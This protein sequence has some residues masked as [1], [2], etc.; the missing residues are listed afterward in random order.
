VIT[1]IDTT[2]KLST[3]LL[4]KSQIP[5]H[6]TLLCKTNHLN[7][8]FWTKKSY[9]KHINFFTGETDSLATKL[10]NT[11]ANANTAT[12]VMTPTVNVATNATT[13]NLN[14]NTPTI[15]CPSWKR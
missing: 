2:E 5:R 8:Q 15:A 9:N 10:K 4:W 3:N 11:A 6:S 1:F 14:P 7:V 13:P 12:N